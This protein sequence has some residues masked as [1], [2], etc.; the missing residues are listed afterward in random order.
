MPSLIYNDSTRR[1]LEQLKYSLPQAIL[2]VG[3]VGVGLATT[4]KDMAGDNLEG[5]VAPTDRDGQIDSTEKGI[6]RIKQVRELTW[7][8][9]K[10]SVKHR[11]YIIDNADQMNKN[12]QNAFL[13]LLEEPS[14]HTHFILTAHRPSLLLPTVRSRVQTVLIDRISNKQTDVLLTKFSI[15]DHAKRQQLLFLANGLPAE[16]YRL[17]LNEKYFDHKSMLM[18]DAK[19]LLQGSPVEQSKLIEEYQKD[20]ANTLSLL[21]AVQTV[22][23]YSMRSTP[24]HE[25]V[26]RLDAATDTYDRITANGNIRLQLT[27][28]LL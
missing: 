19:V 26:S 16:L 21:S 2:L 7:L 14:P 3:E 8:A 23:Q 12:A 20:R 10:S 1:V 18:R 28:F 27:N 22:L 25:L 13:K 4:A 9:V 15:H 11:V 5:F 17:S 24:S 6:I